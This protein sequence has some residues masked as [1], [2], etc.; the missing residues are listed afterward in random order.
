MLRL[1]FFTFLVCF[2]F[3]L[4][5]QHYV[6]VKGQVRDTTSSPIPFANVLAVDTLTGE[7][8]AFAVTDTYGHFQLRLSVDKAYELQCTFVGFIP[9]AEVLHVSKSPL[10]PMV[11][12]LREAV[13]SLEEVTV[14]SEMPVIVSGDTISY[15]AEAFAD[16]DERKLDDVLEDLPGFEVNDNG[17]IRV[18]GERVDKILVDGKPF[19][20]GDTKLA[21]QHIP[22]NVVDRVQVLQNYQE[23]GPLSNLKNSEQ[24]ALNVALKEDKKHLV[25]GDLTAG[26]GPS[27]RYFGHSNV[28]YHT[29]SSSINFIA[30]ANNV[31][32]MALSAQ[33][34]LRMNGGLSSFSEGRG[35]TFKASA[36]QL[37]IPLTNRNTAKHLRGS[38]GALNVSNDFSNHIK[39]TGYVI[40][41][42]NEVETGIDARRMY[43]AS[44]SNEQ[45]LE[46]RLISTSLLQNRS[47]L[48]KL[49]LTYA[50]DL[51]TQ[52][53]YRFLGKRGSFLQSM[54]RSSASASAA[55]PS[56]VS[57]NQDNHPWS[58]M[59]QL[60]WFSAVREQ[61]IVSAR[62][63]YR[64]GETENM[65]QLDSDSELFASFLEGSYSELQQQ[66]SQESRQVE[67]TFDYYYLLNSTTHL[68]GFVGMNRSNEALKAGVLDDSVSHDE[69]QQK[70]L[71]GHQF[72]GTSLRRKQ[73]RVTIE[74]SVS[75]NHYEMETM[76]DPNR[77]WQYLLPALRGEYEM[78]SAHKLLFRYRQTV[79]FSD[80][81]AYNEGLLLKSFNSLS[82]GSSR[83]TPSLFH[84]FSFNYRNFNSYHF[85]NIY[86][87]IEHQLIK[88]R[89]AQNQQIEGFE[90]LLTSINSLS[91]SHVTQL[92]LNAEKSLNH[93]RISAQGNFSLSSLANQIEGSEI[94]T[95]NATQHY[96]LRFSAKLMK[97]WTLRSGYDF[98]VQRYA[99]GEASS[100]YHTH[101]PS[102]S[103]VITKKSVRLDVDYNYTSYRSIGQDIGSIF[104]MLDVSLS[105]RKSKS[106]WEFSV[107]GLNLLDT[108]E[109]RRDNL[110]D[111]LISSY[112][113]FIQPRYVIIK[114]KWD[115]GG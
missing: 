67:C 23:V 84:T 7:M 5:A 73:G 74:P 26:Y 22:A 75:L 52:W 89:L 88:D 114:A 54:W 76:A 17:E 3:C 24:L 109:V 85:F 6:L 20:D 94:E 10:E 53:D 4:S 21:A 28:F 106:P 87:G 12:F 103:S 37:D 27:K 16:G 32:Q 15:S 45:I 107:E 36:D 113:Y 58:Q 40:G 46:E 41:F 115:I 100:L 102:I 38:L 93:W 42:D 77:S 29:P 66:K 105:Y 98:T 33:D 31:G 101:K 56:E 80:V 44:S 61:H 72:V 83:L 34:Y 47:F 97:G 92:Y 59:H 49:S 68:N 71:I 86:A 64:F 2:T 18:Q 9:Y 81:A 13:H 104:T 110:T 63:Q 50:P 62:F 51:H 65:Q 69:Q 57:E 90:N 30:D 55:E 91:L 82:K 95:T 35:S 39:M 14:V 79:E 111:G 99:S 96:S 60:R 43:P 48:A 8:E 112:S 70:V 19:F 11:I 25:F 108:R 1:I 78:S